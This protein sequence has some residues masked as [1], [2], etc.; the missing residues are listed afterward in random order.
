MINMA[1][2]L[3]T[4]T[5]TASKPAS[6]P[7]KHR[8]RRA[9]QGYE[10]LCRDLFRKLGFEHVVTS[11][12]ESKG[13]DGQGIDLMN[14]DELLNGRF[15]YNV[16]CK[17]YSTRIAYDDILNKMSKVPDVINVIF[18]K[19]T[20]KLTKKGKTNADGRFMVKGTFAILSVEDFLVLVAAKREL[21]EIKKKK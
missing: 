14:K 21:D 2:I 1:K 11:R 15:E 9:G 5:V 16:Q 6:V 18:H 3:K 13:R 7:G 19:L 8:N 4:A 12:S 17:C 10:L 20:S